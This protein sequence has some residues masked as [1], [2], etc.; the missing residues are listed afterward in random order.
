M[1]VGTQPLAVDRQTM[2]QAEVLVLVHSDDLAGRW[3]EAGAPAFVSTWNL[4]G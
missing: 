1:G 4:D 2:G 3:A